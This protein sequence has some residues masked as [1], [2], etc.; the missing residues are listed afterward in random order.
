MSRTSSLAEQARPVSPRV[1]HAADRAARAAERVVSL[2]DYTVWVAEEDVVIE[3]SDGRCDAAFFHPVAAAYPGVLVWPDA[4]GLRPVLRDI[5][6]RLAAQGYA[7]L[8]PNLFYRTADAPTLEASFASCASHSPER[9]KLYVETVRHVFARD[10]GDRDAAAFVDFLDHRN[11]VDSYTRIGTHGYCLGGVLAIKTA[12]VLGDRIGAAASLHAGFLVTE[13]PAS[14]HLLAPRISARMYVAI[15][16]ND[17]ARRPDAKDRLK[18]SFA[19]ASV[20]ADVEVYENTEHGWCLPD[21]KAYQ[22]A[23]AA[24]A[25]RRLLA[26]YR[27]ALR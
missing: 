21:D 27:D 11:E 9:Q 19:S 8:V 3:T 10:A 24:R 20:P 16:S 7:V 6:R 2:A 1:S 25:W 13:S 14:P 12:A 5:G 23:P 18:E 17:D 26:L 4:F 22:P 15:A